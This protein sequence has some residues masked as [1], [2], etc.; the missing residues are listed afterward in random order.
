[1]KFMTWPIDANPFVVISLLE[2]VFVSTSLALVIAK[3]FPAVHNQIVSRATR[4]EHQSLY[5]GTAVISNTFIY[6]LLFGTARGFCIYLAIANNIE[7]DISNSIRVIL[8]TVLPIQEIVINVVL[9]VGAVVATLSREN[10]IITPIPPGI[11]EDITNLSFCWSCFCCCVCCSPRCRAKTMT[12]L[13]LFSFMVFIYNT[14]MG[15]VSIVFALFIED[16]R[17]SVLTYSLLYTLIIVFLVF[18]IS[19]L[20]YSLSHDRNNDASTC[21]CFGGICMLTTVFPAVMLMIVMYM[22][23]VFSLDLKGVSGIVTGLIP[24]IVLSAASWYL[25]KRLGK[26]LGFSGA[27]RVRQSI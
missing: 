14:V 3:F 27:P 1:M 15:T 25:K 24:T 16:S 2:Y 12:V 8:T 4:L 18:F 19:F 20:F 21:E 7:F 23:I 9:F 17:A 6:G 11:A 26:R 13:V 22:I 10:S 5:W